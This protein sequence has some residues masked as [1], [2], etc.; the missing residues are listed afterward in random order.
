M[1]A[2]V[3]VRAVALAAG[4]VVA[5]SA[6][7]QVRLERID[8][9]YQAPGPQKTS[10]PPVFPLGGPDNLQAQVNVNAAGLNI[11]GDA[12]NEPSIAVD[13]TAPNRMAIGWRQFDTITNNFRQ[14]GRAWSNDGGRTWHN[15][16]P[17]DPGVF[18]SD[19]V[20]RMDKNGV[21]YYLSLTNTGPGL[22]YSCQTFK[23]TDGGVT[24]GPP[25]QATGGD[26][27][28]YLI[29]TTNSPGSG[30]QYQP[31]S[32]GGLADQAFSRSTD[33][34]ATWLN[35]PVT[36]VPVWGTLDVNSAGDLYV[37]G[38]DFAGSSTTTFFCAKSTNAKNA[39]VTP[40]FTTFNVPMGG[41]IGF[42]VTGSP[43]PGG[44]LGQASLCV[45]RSGG[46]RDGWVYM[47]CSVN[48][49]GTDPCDVYFNRSTD[50]GQTWLAAPIRVNNDAAGTGHWQWFGTMSV[51]PTGRIDVVWNDTRESLNAALSRLYYASS[52]DGGTTWQGNTP[53]GPQ[54]NSTVGYPQ[55]NKIGD[56]YDLVSDKVGAFLAYSATYNNEQDVYFL[57]INDYDCN[58]NGV[59]DATDL[60]TGVLHDCN[61]NGVPDECEIAAGV[62]VNCPPT[63]Y[64]NC[65][66]STLNPFLNVNDF[67]CFL[68]KFAA[69][70]TYANC[71]GST[72]VPVL[73]VNDFSCFTNKYAA[74]CATP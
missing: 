5:V 71:D 62:V 49:A 72:N 73:N 47:L 64:P 63:C 37:G 9:P 41:S 15:P 58:G 30:F 36:P 29:D 7:G 8:M 51:A 45:D 6:F 65:D 10:R 35:P 32:L 61:G 25:V 11:L 59:P 53:I 1:I 48:P 22:G 21:L 40:T 33:Q 24:Y 20:L 54:F 14:A 4:H 3:C 34:A 46:A 43:N 18:R 38:L 17:L 57:R 55:Q 74:G 66:Q 60:A 68:N 2:R 39:A 27:S 13:P 16:G 42:N 69:G 56:Y 12:A 52:D 44:L 28:W 50:G 23:S 26:K 67:S 70:D 31:W 19:P